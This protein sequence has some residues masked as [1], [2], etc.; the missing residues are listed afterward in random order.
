MDDFAD[1]KQ[2]HEFR[3]ISLEFNRADEP[4]ELHAR[5]LPGGIPCPVDPGEVSADGPHR[6]CPLD[7]SFEIQLQ[8]VR[9]MKI[10]KSGDA[11]QKAADEDVKLRLGRKLLFIFDPRRGQ[12]GEGDALYGFG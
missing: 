11:A 5:V 1:S 4:A 8:P 10:V 6:F 2:R 9:R 3:Q 12:K 7:N